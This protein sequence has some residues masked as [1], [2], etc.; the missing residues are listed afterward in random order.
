M[1]DTKPAPFKTD[2]DYL[3]AEI[4]HIRA[5]SKRIGV[6]RQLR[7]AEDALVP[8]RGMVGAARTPEP[9]ELQR[10]LAIYEQAEADIREEIDQRL[11]VNRTVGP[12]LELDSLC[13]EH[14]LG[15]F[16]RTVLLLAVLP[17]LGEDISSVLDPSSGRG[18]VGAFL[19]AQDIWQFMGLGIEERI[20]SR[21][22]LLPT[23]PLLKAGLVTVD[24]G[25]SASPASLPDA[26]IELTSLTFS[27]IVDIPKLAYTVTEEK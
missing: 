22:A 2:I 8:I 25:R 6:Q 12:A 4:S 13:G 14:G 16:E 10:V 3:T 5:R 23:A 24:L 11:A 21:L 20:R 1:P 27:R 9:E 17:A 7:E 18:Y 15:A 19:T 26:R